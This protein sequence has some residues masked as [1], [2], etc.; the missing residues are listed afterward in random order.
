[1]STKKENKTR[2]L[3]TLRWKEGIR[4]NKA[5]VHIVIIEELKIGLSLFKGRFSLVVRGLPI[6]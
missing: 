1:M 2:N 6:Q 4:F 3:K 5:I